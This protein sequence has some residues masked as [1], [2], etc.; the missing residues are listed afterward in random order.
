MVSRRFLILGLLTTTAVAFFLLGDFHAR[1][2]EA[3]ALAWYDAKIEA[4]RAEV[5]GQ[6]GR[7]RAADGVPAGTAGADLSALNPSEAERARMVADI[8]KQLQTEMGLLPLQV[9][10]DRRLSFVELYSSDNLGKTNYGT[11]GYLG[12]G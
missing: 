9:V 2:D 12:G 5:H 6:L 1:T 11:A 10:R 4:I 7:P 3:V 8:K